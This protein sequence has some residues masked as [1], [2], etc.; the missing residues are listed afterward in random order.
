MKILDEVLSCSTQNENLLQNIDYRDFQNININE[1]LKKSLNNLFHGRPVNQSVGNI[2]GVI[3]DIDNS[4]VTSGSMIYR[5]VSPSSAD[6]PPLPL[7]MMLMIA[8]RNDAPLRAMADL[9]NLAVVP[10]NAIQ[11]KPEV[12]Q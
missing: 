9:L 4:T 11:E 3:A 8:C 5:Y 2:V 1:I 7:L 10:K 12:I 6:M